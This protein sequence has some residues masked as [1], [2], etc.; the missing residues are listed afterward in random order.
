MKFFKKVF[1]ILGLFLICSPILSV[2]DMNFISNAYAVDSL[3]KYFI[4]FIVDIRGPLL[5]L[6]ILVSW[7]IG[8][9]MIISAL[10]RI[11]KPGF[12]NKNGTATGTIMMLI[13]GAMLMSLPATINMIEMT[14]F[15]DTQINVDSQAYSAAEDLSYLDAND[16]KTTAIVKAI[17][18]AFQYIRILGLI[19]F[20]RGLYLLKT[21]VDGGQA[22]TFAASLHI[23]GGVL[24]MNIAPVIR[25]FKETVQGV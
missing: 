4:N 18:A 7:I 21:A 15:G 9:L 1:L 23:I 22:S 12:V 6:L 17:N 10:I 19:A 13:I 16:E 24:A 14:I 25:I 3:D 11:T 5:I 20:I 8:L 2:L